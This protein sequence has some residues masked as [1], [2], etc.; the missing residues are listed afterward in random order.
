MRTTF[1]VCS[2]ARLLSLEAERSESPFHTFP[3]SSGVPNS[4]S[5]S[6]MIPL[7]LHSSHNSNSGGGVNVGVGPGLHSNQQ[8]SGP[9]SGTGLT[10]SSVANEA[11]VQNQVLP[12]EGVV[13]KRVM[14]GLLKSVQL[15][16]V[17]ACVH[18]P[19]RYIWVRC[20]LMLERAVSVIWRKRT[21]FAFSAIRKY[22]S[23]QDLFLSQSDKRL[24]Q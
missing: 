18:V 20:G 7:F 11:S 5:V 10:S 1:C 4:V 12:G 15:V 13:L 23:V 17:C 22:V 2:L 19:N 9:L 6:R 3:L 8:S 21:T 24:L 16:R 14:R